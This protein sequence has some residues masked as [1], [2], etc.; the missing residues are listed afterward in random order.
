MDGRLL[1]E[2]A[3]EVGEMLLIGGR[4]LARVARPFL[5]EFGGGH[6]SAT[7]SAGFSRLGM[8]AFYTKAAAVSVIL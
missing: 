4:F 3:A 5:F 2:Q 7:N 6:G 8:G 1:A